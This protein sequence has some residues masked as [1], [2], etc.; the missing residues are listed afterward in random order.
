MLIPH[1]NFVPLTPASSRGSSATIL[2]SHSAW[3]KNG[4]PERGRSLSRSSSSSGTSSSAIL[5]L[6]PRS[7]VDSAT[8]TPIPEYFPYISPSTNDN[9]RGD[10]SDAQN[11]YYSNLP[12]LSQYPP[13]DISATAQYRGPSVYWAPLSTPRAPSAGSATVERGHQHSIEEDRFL[14]QL[15]QM[16]GEQFSVPPIPVQVPEPPVPSNAAPSNPFDYWGQWRPAPPIPTDV[17]LFGPRSPRD[18]EPELLSTA[19]ASPRTPLS[20]VTE[21]SEPESA[22]PVPPPVAHPLSRHIAPIIVPAVT[23]PP[24]IAANDA[25]KPSTDRYHP[26]RSTPIVVYSPGT[27]RSRSR[28]R[29][30]TP[31][32]PGQIT[33]PVS[34]ETIN[35]PP[36]IVS[37]RNSTRSRSRSPRGRIPSALRGGLA[38]HDTF[39]LGPQVHS[40]GSSR[41]GIPPPPIIS[42]VSH[43]HVASLTLA[44]ALRKPGA[45][46]TRLPFSVSRSIIQYASAHNRTF[47]AFQIQIPFQIP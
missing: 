5:L 13:I 30:T 36:I 2:P 43:N 15:R 16:R 4:E 17:G 28:S 20:R 25:P 40:R 11:H 26:Q 46:S 6:S 22:Q 19:P 18:I 21:L 45:V 31:T 29:S 41:S 38:Q 44:L 9:R 47:P 32:S 12:G 35:T 39:D 27:S 8:P 3:S 14:A 24:A 37:A 23:P 34:T 10:Y 42:T 7:S 33:R 1:D